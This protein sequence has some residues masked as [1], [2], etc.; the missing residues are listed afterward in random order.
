MYA[1]LGKKEKAFTL[2]NIPHVPDAYHDSE[3]LI[4]SVLHL[5]GLKYE[6]LWENLRSDPL[7]QNEVRR[8]EDSYN[9]GHERLKTWL[10]EKGMLK[11]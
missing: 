10:E 9:Q 5:H 4:P 6:P 7:F 3:S 8:Y 1:V 11:E 2:I